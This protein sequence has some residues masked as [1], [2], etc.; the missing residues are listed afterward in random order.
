MNKKTMTLIFGVLLFI[1][2]NPLLAQ[3][4]WTLEEC[5]NYAFE[6]NI[7]IKKSIISV[8]SA[9][10]DLLQSK[11]NL[12]P[13]AN[14]SASQSY[15][16]GRN[17]NPQSNLYVTEQTDQTNFGLS[18]DITLFNGLQQINNVRKTQFD[19]LAVKYDSDK[20]RNDIS[21]NVA[22]GYLLIL[23]NIEL[24]KNAERQVQTSQDQV[25]RTTKQ[26]EA[27]A[28]ARGNLFDIQAQ[29]ASEEANLVSAQN[30]LM[31]AYLD[32][33]QLL[34]LE[35]N[36]EFDVEKPLL[37]IIG[38]PTL[39]PAEMIYNKAV[40]LMP[41]IKSAEYRVQSA[42]RSL[43]MAKGMRSPRLSAS[44]SYGSGFSR[45]ILEITGYTPEGAPIFGDIKAFNLQLKDNRSGSVYF[46]L[47]IPIFNG[48]QVTTNINQSKMYQETVDLNLQSEKLLLR[49]NIESSYADAIAAYQT[50]LARKKSVDAFIEAFKYTEEKF[51]VGMVNSTDYNVA[52]IQL[53]NAESD[54]ASS[55]FD[56]I[57][58]TKILDFYLGKTLS[59]NDIANVKVN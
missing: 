30:N 18:S 2:V 57:F 43:A 14:G 36:T 19:Y 55:K 11:L 52:K 22:A 17:L 42:D 26:V 27:G 39:L 37:E 56:Y 41:E 4:E 24:V 51:N 47:N 40:T 16:W 10:A 5:I 9:D 21:L 35:A 38:T 58:K 3:K 48:Y 44:G 49:K 31:L 54:L 33:M 45:Q 12:L 50:Y 59:L 23:F 46:G 6:N 8:E 20:I 7:A 28:L 15:R 13:T 34:D 29:G 25:N 1:S 53:A 32:L